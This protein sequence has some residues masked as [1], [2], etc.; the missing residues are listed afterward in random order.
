MLARVVTAKQLFD[1]DRRHLNTNSDSE[2]L[3]NAF[4]HE[5][6]L[7]IDG[8]MR[9]DHIFHAVRQVHRRVSGG[10]AVV[11]CIIG[12]GILAFRDPNGIRPLVLGKRD[13]AQGT[14][15]MIASESA[16]LEVLA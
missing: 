4:A 7:V 13:T 3:L 6:G 14:D 11:A 2:V 15:Y 10:Y 16:A 8:A 9:P 1:E 12:Q 5:L